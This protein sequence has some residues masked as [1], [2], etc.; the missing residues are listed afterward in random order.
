MLLTKYNHRDFE[1]VAFGSIV[2]KF[3]NDN[4][5]AGERIS[6]FSP[7]V[8]VIESDGEFTIEFFLP[9]I[10]K[11]DIAINVDKGKLT[12]SGERKLDDQQEGKKYRSVES[13]Y[14]KFERSFHLPENIDQE[15]I[16]AT[17]ENGVL[18]LAIPKVEPKETAR[19][20]EIK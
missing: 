14:G 9:G 3:F 4:F 5:F 17:H 19:F 1:P 16:A 11:E 8:D 10:S 6:R 7:K 20:I 12:V 15:A 2:D 13:L 18:R